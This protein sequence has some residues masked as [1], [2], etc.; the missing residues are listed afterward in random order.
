MTTM[1]VLFVAATTSSMGVADAISLLNGRFETT[2]DVTAYLNLALDAAD[3]RETEDI[4]T[5]QNI[6]SNVRLAV[7][8]L[9]ALVVE[10]WFFHWID[11]HPLVSVFSTFSS[12]L[13]FSIS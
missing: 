3:M 10:L 6:Y 5:K 1:V 7:V 8:A 11:P 9:L 13:F 12:S 4:P 2:T